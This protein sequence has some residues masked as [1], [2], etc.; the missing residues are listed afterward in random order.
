M[1]ATINS[2]SKIDT[3]SEPNYKKAV[4]ILDQYFKEFPENPSLD[5]IVTIARTSVGELS[6]DVDFCENKNEASIYALEWLFEKLY[7]EKKIPLE[8]SHFFSLC[9]DLTIK[10][11]NEDEDRK[12][13]WYDN[14]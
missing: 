12:K 8:R 14:I 2:F 1:T 9:G 13:H 5:E 10:Q 11:S 3:A 7:Q 6:T 4:R